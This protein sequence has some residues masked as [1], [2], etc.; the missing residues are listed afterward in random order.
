MNL[1]SVQHS[2]PLRALVMTKSLISVTC[3]NLLT[4]LSPLDF[5]KWSRLFHQ[6]QLMFL[7][8]WQAFIKLPLAILLPT[9]SKCIF[10]LILGIFNTV[11]LTIRY[12]RLSMIYFKMLG[13][14]RKITNTVKELA[15]NRGNS[16]YVTGVQSDMADLS[17]CGP[18]GPTSQVS[19]S[20]KCDF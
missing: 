13:T 5:G 14:N 17:A 4:C 1:R 20:E 10:V 7:L 6:L 12:Q 15:I 19:L 2:T 9:F 18:G 16:C 8:V 3:D 11:Q